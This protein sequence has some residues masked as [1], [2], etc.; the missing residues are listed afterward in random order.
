MK[1]W[2]SLGTI[3]VYIFSN[4]YGVDLNIKIELRDICSVELSNPPLCKSIFKLCIKIKK[5]QDYRGY[6]DIIR[7]NKGNNNITF[8]SLYYENKE[9]SNSLS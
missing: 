7:I 9:N 8:T 3:F 4:P 5:D 6:S 2:L 1:D